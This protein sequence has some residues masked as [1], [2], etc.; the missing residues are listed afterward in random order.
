MRK[1]HGH[2][3]VRYSVFP[4]AHT[5]DVTQERCIEDGQRINNHKMCKRRCALW[6]KNRKGLVAW[7]SKPWIGW[8]EYA[9]LGHSLLRDFHQSIKLHVIAL[10]FSRLLMNQRV[11]KI[12]PV[13]SSA[14]SPSK[15]RLRVRH[16]NGTK[17]VRLFNPS[18]SYLTQNLVGWEGNQIAL[19][20]FPTTCI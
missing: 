7:E 15:S 5:M 3:R 10:W 13:M 17:L 20:A 1:A 8:C 4:L 2:I 11:S 19:R 14:L 12:I 16:T 9:K 6:D 18:H